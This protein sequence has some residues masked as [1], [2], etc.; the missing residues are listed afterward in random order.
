MLP[1][2]DEIFNTIALNS[3]SI[4]TN[5]LFSFTQPRALT[6][7]LLHSIVMAEPPGHKS[8]VATPGARISLTSS[9]FATSESMFDPANDGITTINSM[10]TDCEPCRWDC[11]RASTP[12]VRAFSCRLRTCVLNRRNIICCRDVLPFCHA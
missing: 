5:F 9:I 6:F 7:S 1:I 11:V 3:G 10:Q 2:S 8:A 4:T 12:S